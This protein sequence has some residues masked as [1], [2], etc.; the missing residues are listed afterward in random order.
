[1]DTKLFKDFI[2]LSKTLNF[3][4]SAEERC[5]SQPA[6]SRRIKT[7]ELWAGTPLVDR[8]VYPIKITPAGI[9]FNRFAQKIIHQI[10]I[11]QAELH[12]MGCLDANPI[13]VA[14]SHSL[15]L[16][17]FPQWLNKMDHNL[18]ESPISIHLNNSLNCLEALIQ[19][20]VDFIIVFSHV[21]TPV[22]LDDERFPFSLLGIDK[23]CPVSAVDDQGHPLF[24]MSGNANEPLQYLAYP[25]NIFLGKVVSSILQQANGDI[26][27]KAVYENETAYGLKAMVLQGFGV[28]WLP[29]SSILN[30]L[31]TGQLKQIGNKS[32][33]THLEI[34]LYK[35]K[36]EGKQAALDMW[37]KTIE[38]KN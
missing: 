8:D 29:E 20:N 2:S 6:F 35:G 21:N 3:S 28:A 34:R 27:L 30:E 9:L 32:M 19:N 33:T 36:I 15:A 25:A 11:N 4:R 17:F 22:L 12:S 23:Y 13:T 18:S 24:D 16:D 1:M 31:K 7:L 37:Q 14:S 5:I 10:N 38:Y 26:K